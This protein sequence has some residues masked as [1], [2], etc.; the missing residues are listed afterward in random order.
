M[1]G[2]NRVTVKVFVAQ[3]YERNTGFFLF[4]F[5]FMFGI[6]ESSQIVNYHLSL[7]NGMLS[8]VSF[9]NLVC[10]GWLLYSGKGVLFIFNQLSKPENH[11]IFELSRI[12][13]RRSFGIILFSNV[14]IY[15]PILIYS[16]V[17]F[18]VAAQT[19][20]WNV[21]FFLLVYH[22]IL[23][24]GSSFII[25]RKIYSRHRLTKVIRLFTFKWNAP[26]PFPFFYWN[27]LT[28]KL[29]IVLLVTKLFSLSFILLFL[30][31]DLGHYDIRIALLGFCFGLAGHGVTVF[32]CRRFEDRNM[33]F[34]KG[35][36]IPIYQR[37]L[38]LL[39][40]YLG[41]LIPEGILLL[42]N[43]INPLDTALILL[44]GTAYLLYCHSRLYAD[45]MDMEKHI[46][47]ILVLFLISFLFVLSKVFWIG[48]PLGLGMAYTLL[49]KQYYLYEPKTS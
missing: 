2:L 43:H 39:V 38:Y 20:H 19:H 41:I 33:Y 42:F 21:L 24:A 35:L 31:I 16:T 12:D 5:F 30:Q 9:L 28:Q 26:K 32:E 29:S 27:F 1:R 13:K 36:P 8:S 25:L 49:K 14:L 44:F 7:I 17:I 10:F 48:L 34:L 46:S 18:A 3:F 22:L 11:F 4:I 47:R 23:L 37:F 45:A 6:V 15:L 40:M